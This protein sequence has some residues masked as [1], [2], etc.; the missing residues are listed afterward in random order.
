MA[1][2][3]FRLAPPSAE[4]LALFEPLLRRYALLLA[5][6]NARARLTGPTSVEGLWEEHILDALV[7]LPLL[8][9]KG[10]V[11]DIGT[12]GGLPGLA[13]A[14]ARPGPDSRHRLGRKRQRRLRFRPRR[15]RSDA[16]PRIKQLQ[17]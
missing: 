13:W 12:G 2:P 10:A 3:F 6:A 15:R 5:E 16:Y 7:A 8:P 11:V 9:Q 4:T 14:L 1:S 17:N